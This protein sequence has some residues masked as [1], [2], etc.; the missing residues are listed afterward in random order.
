[1]A[2][3]DAQGRLEQTSRRLEDFR[4][5]TE[6]LGAQL[7][8]VQAVHRADVE[9][10]ARTASERDRFAARLEDFSREAE[11]L[12]QQVLGVIAQNSSLEREVNRLD[13]ENTSFA[14][15]LRALAP[16]S[17]Q[18]N[19][20]AH[21]AEKSYFAVFSLGRTATQWQVS[22]LNR[23]P[24]VHVTH[25]WDLSQSKREPASQG[26]D[27]LR[28]LAR[29]SAVRERVSDIDSA[30]DL[31]ESSAYRVFGNIHG[32]DVL[33]AF[34]HPD[35]LRR[36]YVTFYQTRHPITRLRSI[37]DRWKYEASLDSS[38]QQL[39]RDDAD[40]AFDHAP[41]RGADLGKEDDWL[42]AYAISYLL[43]AESRYLQSSAPIVLFERLISDRD[44]FGW[45]VRQ[46]MGNAVEVDEAMIDDFHATAP[47]DKR[48]A[49]PLAAKAVH[50]S[51]EDWQRAY[52]AQALEQAGT[53]AH[54]A[55]L[56]YEVSF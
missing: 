52:F 53:R 44:H 55:A 16:Q 7:A 32:V 2:L 13:A 36:S 23:H 4:S 42:F 54:Y 49:S 12:G 24:L 30:F 8:Q 45:Y 38:R 17:R 29:Q 15:R 22:G 1:M 20:S 26:E 25:A 35:L 28:S 39:L 51:W 27:F 21:D 11:R 48:G 19:A 9:A 10:L 5:E 40:R 14:H 33:P 34:E 31:I 37:V 46:L 6:R 41:P 43:G 56:G 18:P 3:A 47:I 50:A